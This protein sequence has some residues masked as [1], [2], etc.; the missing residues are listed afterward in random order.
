MTVACGTTS[1][2]RA[3]NSLIPT[4]L[5]TLTVN[6]LKYFEIYLRDFEAYFVYRIRRCLA[7]L[8]DRHFAKLGGTRQT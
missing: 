7:L 2:F 5:Y 6:L 3:T 8:N 1:A 4:I